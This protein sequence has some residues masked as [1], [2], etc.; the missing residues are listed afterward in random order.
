[1]EERSRHFTPTIVV[2]GRP[3]N[4]SYTSFKFLISVTSVLRPVR[5]LRLTY[6]RTVHPFPT[7]LFELI[8][9]SPTSLTPKKPLE[10]S[11]DPS[12]TNTLVNSPTRYPGGEEWGGPSDQNSVIT[13]SPRVPTR[14]LAPPTSVIKLEGEFRINEK[15]P[16]TRTSAEGH[17]NKRSEERRSSVRPRPGRGA[18]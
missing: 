5:A 9:G 11:R 6:R 14:T 16:P 2:S 1:M 8:S 12:V 7:C 18:T 13:R 15:Q 10:P 3:D 4:L 17:P